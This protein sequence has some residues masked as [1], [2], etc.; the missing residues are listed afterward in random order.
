MSESTEKSKA[1]FVYERHKGQR[2]KAGE[3][4]YYAHLTPVALS[5]PNE[6]MYAALAHDILEDTD[7]TVDDLRQ[8]GFADREIAA[9]EAVT[10]TDD[11]SFNSY[12]EKVQRNPDAVVIKVA[13][14]MN[15]ISRLHKLD[16]A[17]Q[18]RLHKK[19]QK[20]LVALI[21]T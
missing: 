5:V 15:N 16:Q 21:T 19:Y 7:T 2:D 9:I 8:A 14:V 17:T 6:L 11:D 4:Y 12:V 3:S 18:E 10:K 1:T 13:D 20:L